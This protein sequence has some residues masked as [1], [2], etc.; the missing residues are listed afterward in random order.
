MIQPTSQAKNCVTLKGTTP[1]NAL[2][3]VSAGPQ[4]NVFNLSFTP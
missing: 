4:A 2:L 3:T 1:G